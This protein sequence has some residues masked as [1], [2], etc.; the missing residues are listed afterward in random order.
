MVVILSIITTIG[1]EI[2]IIII[3]LLYPISRSLVCRLCCF[4]DYGC[5]RR[6]AFVY[7]HGCCCPGILILIM[8]L[9]LQ[10]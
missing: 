6:R 2:I 1:N 8:L 3:V 9:D 5:P 7:C 4:T 10:L